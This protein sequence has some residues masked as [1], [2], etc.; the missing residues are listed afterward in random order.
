MSC[1]QNK[2]KAK[3]SGTFITTPHIGNERERDG[4]RDSERETETE[5]N[6]S[7]KCKQK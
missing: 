2:T 1:Q 5:K 3:K 6:E 7:P 4:D